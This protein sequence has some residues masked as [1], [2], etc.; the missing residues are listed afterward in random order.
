M[1]RSVKKK[2]FKGSMGAYLNYGK[3]SRV[4][5]VNDDDV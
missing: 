5:T 2:K 3:T 4:K 1:Q